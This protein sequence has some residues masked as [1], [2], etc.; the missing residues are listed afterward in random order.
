[1]NKKTKIPYRRFGKTELPIPVI[2]CG[3]MRYQHKWDDVPWED[4]P[5]AGQENIEKV[6]A[7]ALDHGI[8]HIET[9]RGYGSSEMQLGYALKQ[10]DR[11]DYLLQTKVAPQES[12]EKFLQ[13][14]NTSLDYLKEEY[15]DL[16]SIHGINNRKLM[17]MAL[18]PGGALETAL[19]LKE[20]GRVKH[21]GFSTHA[22]TSEIVE[23]INT[24]AFEFV[25]LHWY[26][27]NQLNTP[28]IEAAA[29]QDMGVFIISPN[30]K[31]GQLYKP[32]QKLVELCRPL[33]PMAFNDLFCL[34][35]PRVHTLSCG[36]AQP[37]DFDLHVEAVQQLENA[38]NLIQ[39]IVDRIHCE[40]SNTLGSDWLEHWHQGIPEWE[41]LPGL[42][43]VK[44][45]V[46]L[47]TWAKSIDLVEFATWRYNMLSADDIWVQ[48]NP[49]QDFDAKA[50]REKLSA[51]RFGERILDI[52]YEARNLFGGEKIKKLS[53][54]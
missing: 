33:H 9:A 39:P 19:K 1:M 48:G 13:T 47:W 15:V 36:A 4:V 38:A 46:R 31:G 49:V 54:S 28:A 41:E 14:F 42:I 21:I 29:A 20:Q 25:N 53:E 3:G 27:T 12:E 34:A 22:S 32:P 30:D 45:I 11:K 50:M 40:V 35:D 43:N 5:K 17:D 16:F 18:R 37:S 7:A 52:L 2:S 8:N 10:F 23:L 44:D 26:F 51:N 6:L 24:G